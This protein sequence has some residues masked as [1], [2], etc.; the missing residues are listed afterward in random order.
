[1]KIRAGQIYRLGKDFSNEVIVLVVATA[2]D[3]E[4]AP[5][6]TILKGKLYGYREGST[7]RCFSSVLAHREELAA[8]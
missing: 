4:G 2:L 5:V 8:W 7:L 6:V 3:R 1:M